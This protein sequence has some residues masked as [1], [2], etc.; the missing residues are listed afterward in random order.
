M[1]IL[2]VK[3]YGLWF[4][5]WLKNQPLTC[6]WLRTWPPRTMSM[7]MLTA[8]LVFATPLQVTKIISLET[9]LWWGGRRWAHVCQRGKCIRTDTLPPQAKCKRDAMAMVVRFQRPQVMLRFWTKPKRSLECRRFPLLCEATKKAEFCFAHSHRQKKRWWLAVLIPPGSSRSSSFIKAWIFLDLFGHRAGRCLPWSQSYQP[10]TG[11]DGSIL[12]DDEPL[13]WLLGWQISSDSVGTMA[14]SWQTATNDQYLNESMAMQQ[15]PIYWRYLPYIR[16]FFKAYVRECPDKILPYMLQYL[17]FR[18]LNFPLNEVPMKSAFFAF[19]LVDSGSPVTRKAGISHHFTPWIPSWASS[20]SCWSMAHFRSGL[21]H[22]LTMGR[23]RGS[24]A[25]Q[26]W[27]SDSLYFDDFWWWL[28]LINNDFDFSILLEGYYLNLNHSKS[29]IYV[30]TILYPQSW[31]IQSNYHPWSSSTLH[32]D[33]KAFFV[34]V[35]KLLWPKRRRGNRSRIWIGKHI[36]PCIVII[37]Q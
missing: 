36:D 18:I 37:E 24:E 33:R 16:P 29:N 35:P 3:I 10:L 14:S 23:C 2:T 22:G 1:R 4:K 7:H 21:W 32:G 25:V 6:F 34:P 26:R 27:D 17:H 9:M 28:T 31:H 8:P 11:V 19:P 15:E 30:Y 13:L 12:D 20:S 5:G